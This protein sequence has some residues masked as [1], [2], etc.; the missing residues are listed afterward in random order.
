MPT[1]KIERMVLAERP[2]CG[3]ATGMEPDGGGGMDAV[4]TRQL[5]QNDLA[6]ASDQPGSKQHQNVAE[7]AG[8]DGM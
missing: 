4:G 8:V 7:C 2:D 6:C 1:T 5:L 3:H